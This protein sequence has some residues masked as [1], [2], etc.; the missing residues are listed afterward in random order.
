M[1]WTALDCLANS[2]RED[3]QVVG[4][5]FDLVTFSVADSGVEWKFFI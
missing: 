3:D 1:S 4:A 5:I 2:I